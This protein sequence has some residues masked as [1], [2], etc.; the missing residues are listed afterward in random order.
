MLLSAKY[1]YI[2]TYQKLIEYKKLVFLIIIKTT[3]K[4][5]CLLCAIIYFAAILRS[6]LCNINKDECFMFSFL[7]YLY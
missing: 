2:C 5:T 4:L 3:E 1:I 7:M 6:P